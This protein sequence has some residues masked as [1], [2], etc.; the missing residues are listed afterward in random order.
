MDLLDCGGVDAVV[1][2]EALVRENER[3]T[4]GESSWSTERTRRA[5]E[6]RRAVG[7][8]MC[9]VSEQGKSVEGVLWEGRSCVAEG[10]IVLGTAIPAMLEICPGSLLVI[11]SS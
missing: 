1:E 5:I 4:S 8:G 6:A 7:K 9:R 2:G 10:A 11:I 3:R